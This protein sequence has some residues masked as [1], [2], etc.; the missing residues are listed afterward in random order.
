VK[1]PN[2]DRAVIDEAKVRDYL[3]SP[4]HP[5]G[6]AKSQFFVQL[7]FERSRWTV[8]RD[9][10]LRLGDGD[11]ELGDKTGFG[12]KYVVRATIQHPASGPAAGSS[13]VV[14]FGLFATVRISRG[15]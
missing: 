12:Q 2:V 9:A 6:R 13:A 8:L 10:L 11:A 4:E 1:I 3:L 7:G 5:V 14:R 15:L